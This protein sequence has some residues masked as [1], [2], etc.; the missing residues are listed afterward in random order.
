MRKVRSNTGNH[1]ASSARK[2]AEKGVSDVHPEGVFLGD[3]VFFQAVEHSPVAIS[4]TDLKANILYVNRAFTQITGY[5]EEEVLGENESILSNHTTPRLVYQALWG[6]LAQ[7]KPWSGMLLNRRRDGRLYLAELT[8]APVIDEQGKTIHF[9]GMHRD[10]SDLHQ[11]E[12]RLQNQKQMLESTLNAMPAAVI[13]LDDDGNIVTSNP[14]FNQL[15]RNLLPDEPLMATAELFIKKLGSHYRQLNETGRSFSDKETTIDTASGRPICYSCFGTRINVRDEK[16]DGFFEQ[17]EK[18]ATLLMISDI[19][20]L[21]RRQ[22][23]VRLNALRALMAEED[24]VQGMKETVNGAIHQLQGPVNLM[25]TAV[26]MLRRRGEQR[27][28]ALLSA[29]EDGLKSGREALD[30]LIR[31]LPKEPEEERRAVNVNEIL[32][33][34]LALNTHELLASGVTVNWEPSM[35]LPA[36]IGREQKLRSMFRHLLENAIEAM[37]QRGVKER[38]LTIRTAAREHR[39]DIEIS[40]TGPGIPA[41]MQVRVFEP[42]FTTKN[43][44]G[45]SRGM[46]LTIVQDVVTDHSGTIQFDNKKAGKGCSVLIQ[47]PLTSRF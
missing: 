4:I 16:A 25:D 8:V 26:S 6:R 42:F 19:S 14:G 17:P 45:S 36:L 38:E 18:H 24:L 22:E 41:E 34:V 21:R 30:N 5:S 1:D 10:G 28:S 35:Q 15:A 44:S 12:Q 2:V 23:E 27:D 3:E 32:R 11:L 9:L 43:T 20:E 47:L 37:A 40:D 29:L 33:D 31:S 39:I 7:Q 46:G 13:V